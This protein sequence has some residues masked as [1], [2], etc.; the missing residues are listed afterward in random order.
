MS[1]VTPPTFT[2]GAA[3]TAAQMNILAADLNETA[4]AKATAVSQYFVSNVANSL[5]AK[6]VLTASI[7]VAETTTSLAT[8]GDLATVG[9][10]V[11]VVINS[12]ALI[13][14]SAMMANGTGGGGGLLSYGISGATTRAA[15]NGHP[16]RFISS[17]ANETQSLTKVCHETGLTGGTH[18]VGLKY[19][20][21]TG[22]TCTF[23][24]RDIIVMPF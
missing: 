11:T 3:L 12:A 20:T 10:S 8:Y 2:S 17:N 9:P 6:L 15:P 5:T 19:T 22:G 1:W 24:A 18:V 13:S 4:T 23:N 16:L 14:Q 7:D 21:P